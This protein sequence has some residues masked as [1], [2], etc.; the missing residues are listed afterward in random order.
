MNWEKEEA[1]ISDEGKKFTWAQAEGRNCLW[2]EC[3]ELQVKS[4]EILASFIQ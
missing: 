1:G 2:R 4:W 3:M